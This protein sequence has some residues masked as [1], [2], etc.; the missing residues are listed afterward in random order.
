MTDDQIDEI[1]AQLAERT[2]GWLMRIETEP[3]LFD[4]DHPATST[5]GVLIRDRKGQALV[6][7]MRISDYGTAELTARM[8]SEVGEVGTPIVFEAPDRSVM[9][10]T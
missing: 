8:H 10:S 6:V 7:E 9:I 3:E 1:E 2:G 4:P 5:M